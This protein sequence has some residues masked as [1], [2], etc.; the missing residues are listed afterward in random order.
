MPCSETSSK[1][2]SERSRRSSSGSSASRA[3]L[4]M[5]RAV[6][7]FFAALVVGLLTSCVRAVLVPENS[8][9]RLREPVRARV[10]V[11]DRGR[12]TESANRVELPEG[13]YLVPPSFVEEAEK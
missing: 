1:A 13:W 12:W 6:L 5:L 2:S 7:L 10:Y 8:P 11:L 9:V 4:R 3:R